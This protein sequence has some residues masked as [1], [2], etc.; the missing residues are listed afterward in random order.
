MN[1]VI[2]NKLLLWLVIVLLVANAAT[3]S[4]LWLGRPGAAPRGDGASNFLIKELNLDAKQQEQYKNLVTEHR[5]SVELLRSK[6]RNSKEQLFDMIKGEGSSDS[7]KQEKAKEIGGYSAE[8][9]LL[10]VHHFEKLRAI[11][12]PEQQTKFDSLLHEVTKMMGNPRPPMGPDGH[13]PPGPPPGG[14]GAE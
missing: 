9:D 2:S 3:L 1:K 10:T 8:L 5:G 13:R 12:T 4:F 7:T 14:P 6:I 11:C